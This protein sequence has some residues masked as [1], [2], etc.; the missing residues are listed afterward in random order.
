MKM[1]SIGEMAKLM[2]I[3]V[4]ML[5]R[6]SNI[7]LISPCY[8]NPDTGYRFYDASSF[9][10]IDRAKYLQKLGF[11]LAEIKSLYKNNDINF[12]VERLNAL[13][14]EVEADIK[15]KQA[16]LDE[17]QWYS[18][19]FSYATDG[20]MLNKA[21]IRYFPERTA[22]LVDRFDGETPASGNARLYSTKNLP[23]FKKLDYRRQNIILYNTDAFFNRILKP[24]KYGFYL[25]AAPSFENSKFYTFRQGYYICFQTRVLTEEWTPEIFSHFFKDVA[26][27]P[28]IIADEY[29]DD[30]FRFKR[31]IYEVQLYFEQ[32]FI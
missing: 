1:Y 8:I 21:Y 27:P 10:S 32:P 24:F 31:C 20:Q 5:R 2:G 7:G 6:Y 22:F 29:E 26:R 12:L 15:T 19:F 30:L 28:Y 11:S 4:Q 23:E 18:R 17:L 9:S 16:L 25:K 14:G 13:A 3:S